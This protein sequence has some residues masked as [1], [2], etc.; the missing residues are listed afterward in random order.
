M[1]QRLLI[2]RQ[3]LFVMITLNALAKVVDLSPATISRVLN[4]NPSQRISAP[5]RRLIQEAARKYGYR[6]NTAARSLVTR[7]TLNIGLIMHY[8]AAPINVVNP[9]LLTGVMM[10]LERTLQENHYGLNV[11]FI[12]R[13][14]PESSFKK[15][16]TTHR[17]FDAVAFPARVATR[18][19]IDMAVKSKVPSTVIMDSLAD[20]WPTNYFNIEEDGDIIRAVNYLVEQGH[21]D[22]AIIGWDPV[23]RLAEGTFSKT[24]YEALRRHGIDVPMDWVLC[25]DPGHDP[26]FSHRDH[27]RNAMR[28]IL[29][30]PRR[31]SAV[32]CRSD[33]MVYGMMDALREKGLE[34][35]RDVAA[36]GHGNIEHAANCPQHERVV[37]TFDLPLDELG[38]ASAEALLA[39]IE[40][41]SIPNQRKLYPSE[42][43]V[44]RS[45]EPLH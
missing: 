23:G 17:S 29:R 5:K 28:Q 37:T 30:S 21:R 26:F 13:E 41:S 33:F 35:G 12:S 19:L 14:D 34:V 7:K 4:G 15:L 42:L 22:V 18:R 32:V 10:S 2:L 38:R 6:P 20:D 11:V 36:I 43:V 27:G 44:R 1:N 40:N 16:L 9:T 39:Q 3:Q 45:S 24:A 31:P 8:G 25:V